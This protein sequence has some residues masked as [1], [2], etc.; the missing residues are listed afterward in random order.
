M[1]LVTGGTGFLGRALVRELIKRK[2]N[3]RVLTRRKLKTKEVEVYTGDITNP[4]DVEKAMRGCIGVFHLAAHKGHLDRYEKH[5]SVNVCGTDYVLH[6]AEKL[7]IKKV[8]VMSTMAVT[9][10]FD[11]PYIKAK[12]E[13][14]KI[15]RRH[16]RKTICPVIRAPRIYDKKVI[17]WFQKLTRY[18]APKL[19]V[20]EFL[21]YRLSVVSA[22]IAAMKDGKSKIYQI[23]DKKPVLFTDFIKALN[24]KVIWVSP[25][26]VEILAYLSY[27]IKWFSDFF[28]I[29]PAVTP[30]FIRY[31]FTERVFQTT[32]DLKYKR[33]N[34]LNMVRRIVKS[35]NK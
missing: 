26:F 33:Y 24:P 10:N 23:A 13:E 29:K 12:Q 22:L 7:G 9:L 21:I 3:V 17:K 18:A 2:L 5:Y 35:F 32:K 15:V 28:K 27:P 30:E 14:E 31:T 19:F 6:A 11:T 1:Y 8:V 34:T 16:W 20:K 25:I 4:I